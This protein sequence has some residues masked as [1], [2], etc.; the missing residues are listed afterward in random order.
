MA[1]PRKQSTSL[2]SPSR[3]QPPLPVSSTAALSRRS[4]SLQSSTRRAA[5]L[6]NRATQAA[7]PVATYD[8]LSW[9]ESKLKA[10]RQ[11]RDRRPRWLRRWLPVRFADSRPLGGHEMARIKLAAYH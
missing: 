4:R 2:E 1:R 11:H 6:G 7:N 5:Y 8:D 3:Q 10:P 9:N